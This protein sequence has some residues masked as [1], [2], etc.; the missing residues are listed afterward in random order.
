MKRLYIM[1][2]FGALNLVFGTNI[3]ADTA[4]QIIYSAKA[5]GH[6]S[7]VLYG[8]DNR[9]D[10]E[11]YPQAEF[12]EFSKSTAGMV[13]SYKLKIS[14]SNPEIIKFSKRKASSRI[15]LCSDQRFADQY[16]LTDCTGFLIAPDVLVTAGHCVKDI[17]DCQN[18][19]WVFGFTSGVEEFKASDVYSCKK[20]L[21]R[22]DRNSMFKLQDYALIRLDRKVEDRT[23]LKYRTKGRVRVNTPLVVIGHPS[24]LPTKI[25]DEARVSRMNFPEI[26]TPVNTL[27]K[28]RYYFIANLDAFTGNSGSP[29]FNKKSGLVEGILVSG[30]RDYLRR[31]NRTCQVVIKRKSSRW[32]TKEKVFRITKIP[33]LEK[34]QKLP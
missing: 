30:A 6:D 28:K 31:P 33:E 15:N 29:V 9:H 10:V 14:S 27:I 20:I 25:A 3:T 18:F 34:L 23:P 12:R 24:G 17:R 21:A 32:K 19:K 13:K 11:D 2:M 8:G 5:D 1:A 16:S 7:K 22:D 4:D 26:L